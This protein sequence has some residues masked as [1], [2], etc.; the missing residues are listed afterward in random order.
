MFP[1]QLSPPP[2]TPKCVGVEGGLA[3]FPPP[4]AQAPAP[5]SLLP[6]R[7][8]V[9]QPWHPPALWF[10][11]QALLAH[12]YACPYAVTHGGSGSWQS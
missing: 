12:S 11:E 1:R 9:G 5:S 6:S 7:R 10:G 3:E 8:G 2:A 4:P